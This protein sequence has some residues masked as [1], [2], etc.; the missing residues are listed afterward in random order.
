M[1]FDCHQ[2][3]ESLYIHWP[4]CP[5]RCHFCPFVALA[6]QDEHMDVYHEALLARDHTI[7]GRADRSGAAANNLF[8][9]WYAKYVSTSIAG[10][11]Y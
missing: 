1:Q 3:V 6:G 5:Y 8:W 4:F 9:R 7:P 11:N 10:T 2:R